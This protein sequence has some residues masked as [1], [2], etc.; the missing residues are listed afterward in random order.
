MTRSQGQILAVLVLG[1]AARL[2][3]STLGYTQ[4]LN[5]TQSWVLQY[6]AGGRAALLA[7]T[8]QMSTV[9]IAPFV[10]VALSHLPCSF[11]TSLAVFLTLIDAAVAG[12]LWWS[13]GGVAAA[14]FFLNPISIIISGYQRV[15]DN[16]ALLF[17]FAAALTWD[18]RRP[19]S[20]ALLL[21]GSLLWKHDLVLLPVWLALK[22]W[23]A[24]PCQ[25]DQGESAGCLATPSRHRVSW[26]S[27]ASL[28]QAILCFVI[29][30]AL[31]LAGL[32]LYDPTLRIVTHM[33]N[34]RSTAN[35]PLW[36]AFGVSNLMGRVPWLW[37]FLGAMLLCGL[38]YRRCTAVEAFAVYCCCLVAFSTA[39][40]NHYL[41]IPLAGLAIGWN[42]WAAA[43]TFVGTVFELSSDQGLH[44]GLLEGWLH[45]S[46]DGTGA[47]PWYRLMCLCLLLHLVTRNAPPTK[48][49]N[50]NE[51]PS[52]PT[53]ALPPCA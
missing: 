36:F 44:I 11:R 31:W 13:V 53:N 16:V 48:H 24:S 25:R 23:P 9:P 50:S 7:N 39:L 30:Y 18:R 35:A 33:V 22:P 45:V 51:T 1:V 40:A 14:L 38:R 21:G 20:A 49:E 10:F 15:T 29:P 32:A 5:Y 17:G 42:R 37:L 47:V 4:D 46:G 41:A 12:L 28:S 8:I 26:L 27:G 52:P 3:V 34:Y 19:F 43:Y 2:Y 6:H